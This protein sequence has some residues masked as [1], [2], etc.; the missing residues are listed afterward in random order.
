MKELNFFLQKGSADDWL[1]SKHASDWDDNNEVTNGL[2][3]ISH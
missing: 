2:Q 3:L 1:S